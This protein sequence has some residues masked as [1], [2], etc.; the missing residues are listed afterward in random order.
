MLGGNALH[1]AINV[2]T[3]I[4]DQS[5]IALE[6]LALMSLSCAWQG[7][8][9]SGKGHKVMAAFVGANFGGYR[10]DSGYGQQKLSL[11][12]LAD[13]SGWAVRSHLLR[14]C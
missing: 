13:V 12:Q 9:R 1:G 8:Y 10:D 3:P 6:A 4:P 7:R 14:H 5:L 2:I 11:S